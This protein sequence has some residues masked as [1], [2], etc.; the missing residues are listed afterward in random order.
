[1]AANRRSR[2]LFVTTKIELRAIAAPATMGLSRPA[3][4]IGR[5]KES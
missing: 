3:A 2:R 5:A 1:M 4:A